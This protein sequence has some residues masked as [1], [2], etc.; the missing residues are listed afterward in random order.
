[1][2]GKAD[3]DHAYRSPDPRAY[4]EVLAPLE[5]QIPQRALPAIER[6]VALAAHGSPGGDT[7]VLDLC[8]S[9]GFNAA[10][11]RCDVD[12]PE[13]TTRYTHPPL[14]GLDTAALM[15][16]DRRFYAGRRRRDAPRVLGLDVAAPAVDY[17]VAAGMMEGGWAEDL[18]REEPSAAL[19]ASLRDLDVISCTGGVGYVGAA[20]FDRVL[21]LVRR[22]ERVWVVMFVL[23]MFDATEVIKVL[24]GHG[25]VTERVPGRPVRQRRFADREEQEVA[26]ARVRDRG[27][28][29]TGLEADGWYYA[30]CFL[31]RPA[32]AAATP[33]AEALPGELFAR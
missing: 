18:E 19:A 4:F 22:P 29:P 30:D 14:R 15:E 25:L 3:F 2:S 23:R 20:T 7:T 24:A 8:C 12:L 26:V 16:E 1:M 33:L 31:A 10:L 9:Y 28:D 21:R 17:A 13:M 11:L 27:L 5:Y 32:D 6:T